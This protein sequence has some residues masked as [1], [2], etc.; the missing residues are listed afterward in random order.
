[1]ITTTQHTIGT[2]PVLISEA[3]HNPVEIHLHSEEHGNGHPIYLG[4]SDVSTTTGYH[5]QPDLDLVL[6]I[7]AGESLFAVSDGAGREL[8]VIR[9]AD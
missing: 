6:N 3:H 2:T 1:M 7:P 5:I 8:H 9:I 4:E